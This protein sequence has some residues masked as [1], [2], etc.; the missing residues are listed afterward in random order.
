[1]LPPPS[2]SPIKVPPIFFH[3]SLHITCISLFASFA[4]LSPPLFSTLPDY[5]PFG[6]L[7]SVVTPGYTLTSEELELGTEEQRE[8]ATLVFLG[9]G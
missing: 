6:F 3:F 4:L 8:C 2:S 7:V 5:G 1:M 9:L